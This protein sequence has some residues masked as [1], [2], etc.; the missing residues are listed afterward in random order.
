MLEEQT[1]DNEEEDDVDRLERGKKSANSVKEI[2]RVLKS[3]DQ[4]FYEERHHKMMT[5]LRI[6]KM[7]AAE[8]IKYPTQES[9]INRKVELTKLYS[10][11]Q[12]ATM[13]AQK[14]KKK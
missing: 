4:E 5:E 8:K 6:R 14:I 9:F 13:S 7:L 11:L 1:S 2:K 10:T 3:I 12:G